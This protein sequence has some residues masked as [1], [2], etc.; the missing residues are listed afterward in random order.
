M[1]ASWPKAPCKSC[2]QPVIWAF[3]EAG[4]RIAVDP[5]PEERGTIALSGSM[6]RATVM[7]KRGRQPGQ[8]LY[9]VH[10]DGCPGSGQH[11]K[12]PQ[13][14]PSAPAMP[15]EGLFSEAAVR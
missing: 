7:S 5:I 2:N 14:T 12:A 1:S 8:R 6:P 11:R 9:V 4:N 3:T 10:F 13:R 15:Q